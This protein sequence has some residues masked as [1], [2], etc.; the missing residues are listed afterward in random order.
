MRPSSLSVIGL[1]AIGGSLAWQARLA[2]VPRIVG[3]SASRAEGVEALRAN[4]ITELADHPGGEGAGL[5]RLRAMVPDT[6]IQG[7]FLARAGL[8]SEVDER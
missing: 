3:C 4:A 8:C 5:H 7:F 2:G 1:G 6:E